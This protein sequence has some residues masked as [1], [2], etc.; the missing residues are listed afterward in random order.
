MKKIQLVLFLLLI[1]FG[2]SNSNGLALIAE[3]IE[4]PYR[5]MHFKLKIK[6]QSFEK[7]TL[8]FADDGSFMIDY[9]VPTIKFIAET[10]VNGK[11]R[12]F[13]DK[14]IKNIDY[15]PRILEKKL[16]IINPNEEA[17]IGE[18]YRNEEL[19]HWFS[20]LNDANIRLYFIYQIKK[21]HIN[22]Q[23]YSDFIKYQIKEVELES[24]KIEYNYINKLNN[25]DYLIRKEYL[26][27]YSIGLYFEGNFKNLNIVKNKK[28]LKTKTQY[29][30]DVLNEIL[31]GKKFSYHGEIRTNL[32]TF[33]G[34][35]I[36]RIMTF[37][38]DNKLRCGVF[39]KKESSNNREQYFTE[40]NY[41]S[42]AVTE[43]LYKD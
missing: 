24:N 5:G 7:K 39:F 8:I 34:F 30:D 11:W 36:I 35:Q 18:I 14:K 17:L 21:P 22:N 26:I 25:K 32:Y 33:S 3:K 12:K 37:V 27:N 1:Q 9:F 28:L 4:N 16:I 10:N 19:N 29:N 42:K 23:Y 2:F 13:K 31:N 43:F 15:Y 6:N 20:F 41:D 38:V 40:F